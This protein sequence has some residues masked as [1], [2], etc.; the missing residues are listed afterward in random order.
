M[1]NVLTSL[2][3]LELA[4]VAITFCDA[5]P[6]G[7]PRV[8]RPEPA[9]CGY[10]RRAAEGESFYTEASDQLGCAVGAH[11]HNVPMGPEKQQE[12]QGLIGTMVGLEYLAMAEVPAIP[13]R[14]TAFRFAVYAPLDQASGPPDVVLVRANVRQLMLLTEAARSAG[15]GT[16]GPTL[17]RPT[18]AVLPAAVNAARSSSS[19]GCVG[20]RVYTGAADDEGYFAVPGDKLAALEARLAVV[21]RANTELRKFHEQ[22]LAAR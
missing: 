12:L 17:G 15:I 14:K 4:P 2:L 10:W 1:K 11:T 9:S 5:P 3:G 20:N 6:A 16:G 21:V 19:F 7:V 8:S 13:Q 22:R 18:C